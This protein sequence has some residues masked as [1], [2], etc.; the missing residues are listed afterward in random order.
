MGL[1]CLQDPPL[2]LDAE[3]RLNRPLGREN[4]APE[5]EKNEDKSNREK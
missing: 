4:G 3:I 2:L 1:W 5:R